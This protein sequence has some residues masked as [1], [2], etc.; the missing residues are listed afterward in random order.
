MTDM[1]INKTIMLRLRLNAIHR[2]RFLTELE[3][4]VLLSYLAFVVSAMLMCAYLLF[5]G[6]SLPKVCQLILALVLAV[7]KTRRILHFNILYNVSNSC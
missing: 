3:K 1:T 4:C 7:L 6:I 5:P 2:I